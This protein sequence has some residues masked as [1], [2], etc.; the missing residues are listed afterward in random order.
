MMEAV[1]TL[2]RNDQET[3][4]Q[5]PDAVADNIREA[6][7]GLQFGEINITV[8]NGSVTQIERVARRR[9]FKSSRQE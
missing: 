1:T 9:Q 8:R 6:L 3:Q 2:S 5:I 7:R 4:F